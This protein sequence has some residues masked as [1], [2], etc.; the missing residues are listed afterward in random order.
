MKHLSTILKNTATLITLWGVIGGFLFIGEAE[1]QNPFNGKVYLDSRWTIIRKDKITTTESPKAGDQIVREWKAKDKNG[2]DVVVTNKTAAI[3]TEVLKQ[4]ETINTRIKKLT[5][6]ANLVSVKDNPELVRVY[7]W[8]STS[9]TVPSNYTVEDKKFELAKTSN[10]DTME[11]TKDPIPQKLDTPQHYRLAKLDHKEFQRRKN[12][13]WITKAKRIIDVSDEKDTIK[14]HLIERYGQE[15]EYYIKF[16]EGQTFWSHGGNYDIGAIIV[17]FK[18]YLKYDHTTNI[19]DSSIS[20][21][22]TTVSDFNLG[23]FLGYSYGGEKHSFRS[24]IIR[25]TVRIKATFGATIGLGKQDLTSKNTLTA[26]TPL[27]GDDKLAVPIMMIGVGQ[28]FSIQDIKLAF[29][30]GTD[31]GL[32]E[33]ARSWDHH[34]KLWIGFGIGYNL[35]GLTVGKKD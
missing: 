24:G 1:A 8:N 9:R 21:R 22:G 11:F 16:N 31:L 28:M 15:E 6:Y 26:T 33:D 7:F 27:T 20:V 12:E 5:G 32:T 13:D 29:F 4:T 3:G 19:P 14:Y 2:N 25:N 23:V 30:V 18:Y 17:P 34:A 10:K 35:A